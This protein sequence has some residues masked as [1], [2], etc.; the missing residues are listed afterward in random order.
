MYV[1]T[2]A[3]ASNT[4]TSLERGNSAASV[5]TPDSALP[6]LP[7]GGWPRGSMLSTPV[8][9]VSASEDLNIDEL[10]K[11]IDAIS[12][13]ISL[14]LPVSGTQYSEDGLSFMTSESNTLQNLDISE[15]LG[16]AQSELPMLPAADDCGGFVSLPVMSVAQDLQ[17]GSDPVPMG[18][19]PDQQI[20]NGTVLDDLESGR[21][22][23]NE[24][25]CKASVGCNEHSL[26][27]GFVP[28]SNVCEPA[29]QPTEDD[30]G[31][32]ESTQQP[33]EEGFGSSQR[34][35]EE[36]F[37]D[38]GSSQH[39]PEEDFGDFG[40]SQHPSEEEFGDFGS[41]QRP[42]EEDFGDFGSSQHP[43]EED[44]GGF[45]A[46]QRPPEGDFGSSQ[47][48]PEDD[49]GDFGSAAPTQVNNSGDFSAAPNTVQEEFGNFSSASTSN[50]NST[51]TTVSTPK[52][53]TSLPP[54]E[55]RGACT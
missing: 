45:G 48:P 33:P 47:C 46:S 10:A 24:V 15:P 13:G 42:P 20:D 25:K 18:A 52:P 55:V 14:T 9:G 7:N 23:T 22:C 26:E 16:L 11:E 40:S 36:D 51:K 32:F 27:E 44:F 29:L 5:S 30:F 17:I 19:L 28:Q 34:P 4:V 49:F 35:P 21:V 2:F 53:S 12:Q 6:P 8:P 31:D 54:K 39:P 37:G 38:F 43:P 1:G 3:S 41:S 50:S